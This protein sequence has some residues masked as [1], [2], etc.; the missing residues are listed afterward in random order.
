MQSSFVNNEIRSFKRKLMK[1]V[2]AHQHASILEMSSDWKLFTNHG[3]QLIGLG[4]EV[5]SKQIVSHT[6][7]YSTRPEKGPPPLMLNWNSN[8]S[9][10]D[11]L[12]Q[13]RVAN[14]TSSRTKK[15]PHQVNPMIFYGKC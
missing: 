15:N 14:R 13:R 5:L 7:I 2:R 9:Y 1:S 12:H 11:S 10:T 8:R 4:K 3:L 6:H